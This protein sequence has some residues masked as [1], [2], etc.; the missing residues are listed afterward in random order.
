MVNYSKTLLAISFNFLLV[1]Q[2]ATSREGV[3]VTMISTFE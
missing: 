3:K 2:R 1:R